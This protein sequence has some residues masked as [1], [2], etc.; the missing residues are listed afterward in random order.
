M[1]EEYEFFYEIPKRNW[2]T[3]WDLNL[4]EDLSIPMFDKKATDKYI[5]SLKEKFDQFYI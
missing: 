3:L 4:D 1:H 5:Q 2:V